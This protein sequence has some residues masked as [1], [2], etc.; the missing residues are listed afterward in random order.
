[1]REAFRGCHIWDLLGTSLPCDPC[2][3][4]RHRTAGLSLNL[5]ILC[6]CTQQEASEL[7]RRAESLEEALAEERRTA[8]MAR[9]VS[10]WGRRPYSGLHMSTRKGPT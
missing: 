3:I 4:R 5:K 8:M 6:S 10:A 9:Q 2:A 1:M 7:R